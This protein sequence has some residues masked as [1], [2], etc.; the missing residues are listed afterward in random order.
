MKRC[1]TLLSALLL[2]ALLLTS[3]AGS[4]AFAAASVPSGVNARGWIWY[5]TP[6]VNHSG[7][8]RAC[9]IHAFAPNASNATA[10]ATATKPKRRS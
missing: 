3:F 5:I 1:L 10:A 6:R 2:S 7:D 8:L 9:C 4:F